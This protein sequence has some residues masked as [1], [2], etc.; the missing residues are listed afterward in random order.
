M[1]LDRRRFALALPMA[2]VAYATNPAA[3]QTNTQLPKADMKAG[4]PLMEA[5]AKRRSQRSFADKPLSSEQMSR[6]L[7]AAFGVNRPG[8]DGRTA[9]SWRGSKET[10]IYVATAEGVSRYDPKSH[11]LESYMSGDIRAKTGR[12]EFPETAPAVL[13]YVADYTRMAKASRDEQRLYAHVDSAIIAQNV[14]LFAASE[15]LATVMLGNVE[16]AEL[17]KTLKLPETQIVTFTQPI[18]SPG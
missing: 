18:G 14:Y 12:Q 2:A 5:L 13:I 4:M 3:A 11:A 9:P 1:T 17:A 8:E 16:K 10:D 15:G 7:W 6:L